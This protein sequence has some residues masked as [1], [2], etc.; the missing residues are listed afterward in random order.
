MVNEQDRSRLTTAH[1]CDVSPAGIVM[2]AGIQ[3]I[4]PGAAASGSALTVRVPAGDN[5]SLVVAIGRAAPGDLLVVDAGGSLERA[6]WGA[7]LSQAAAL[8]GIAGLVIDGA[9]R[10]CDEISQLRFPVFARGR[11]PATPYSK[12]HGRVGG[13]IVCGGLEV[14]PGDAVHAD[15]DGVVVIPKDEHADIVERALHRV[16]LEDQVFNGLGEGRQLDELLPILA[17][18]RRAGP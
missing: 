2:D 11:T 8:R 6:L 12:I 14:H 5:A 13:T 7:V 15:G 9:V 16:D 17:A 10:D 4:W 1:L 18:T 3:A